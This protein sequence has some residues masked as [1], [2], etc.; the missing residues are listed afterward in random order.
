MWQKYINIYSNVRQLKGSYFFAGFF[1]LFSPFFQFSKKIFGFKQLFP[2]ASYFLIAFNFCFFFTFFIFSYFL[3]TLY[4]L[5]DT[6][7]ERTLQQIVHPRMICCF[8]R[9]FLLLVFVSPLYPLF[10]H[11]FLFFSF[12]VFLKLSGREELWFSP[13]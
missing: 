10:F 5:P 4:H 2:A 8:R 13:N 11:F 7:W 12:S 3:L 9:I 1:Y 6:I